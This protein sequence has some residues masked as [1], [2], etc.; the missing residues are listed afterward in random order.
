MRA[1]VGFVRLVDGLNRAVGR[2]AGWLLF[3]SVFICAFVAIARYGFAFGRIWLQE[4]YV[5]LFG[6]G[7][8]LA[9]GWTYARDAHVRV[10]IFWRRWS[11]R[12][13]ARIELLGV[14]LFLI[15]WLLVL[16]WSSRGFVALAWSVREPSPQAGGLPGLYLVKTVIPLAAL[17]LLLQGLAALARS[18]LELAGRTDLLPPP[19][20]GAAR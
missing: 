18:L 17:L 20:G 1:L 19:A 6:V 10:D 4:L 2:L 14:L 8:M 11:A 13:R 7:F 5:V 16:L 3:G 15:P 9:A 12:T